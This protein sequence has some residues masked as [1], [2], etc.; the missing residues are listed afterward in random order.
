MAGH[1]PTVSVGIVSSCWHVPTEPHVHTH[2]AAPVLRG[3]FVGTCWWP[4]FHYYSHGYYYSRSAKGPEAYLHAQPGPPRWLN[5]GHEHPAARR[6]FR[7]SQLAGL[8]E[9][10][11]SSWDAAGMG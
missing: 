8:R 2:N 3:G 6:S 1:A 9:G 10:R 11:G 7:L 5:L 4:G